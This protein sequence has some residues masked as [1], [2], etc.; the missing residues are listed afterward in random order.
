MTAVLLRTR[1]ATIA[2]SWASALIETPLQAFSF[3]T[4]S[5]KFVGNCYTRALGKILLKKSSVKLE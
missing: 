4:A 1:G 5:V 2:F 3:A